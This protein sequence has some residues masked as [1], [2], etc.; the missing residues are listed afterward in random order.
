MMVMYLRGV[1]KTRIATE[2]GRSSRAIVQPVAEPRATMR[3]RR[4]RGG[5]NLYS[6]PQGRHDAKR[7]EHS[8]TNAAIC[9]IGRDVSS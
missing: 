5:L 9:S 4:L 8:D 6:E 1:S 2:L 3:N 7:S